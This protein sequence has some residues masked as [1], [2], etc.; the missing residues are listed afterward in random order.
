MIT[1]YYRCFFD[2]MLSTH[3]IEWRFA[4]F[5][6]RTMRHVKRKSLVLGWKYIISHKIIS[7]YIWLYR[8]CTTN[9]YTVCKFLRCGY[10]CEELCNGRSTC[11]DRT[12]AHR[13]F[14][15]MGVYLQLI[16][17]ISRFRTNIAFI[18]Q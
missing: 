1:R 17:H 6:L 10:I 8:N 2:I 5:F 15:F 4:I 13:T 3:F 18:T 11:D 7:G 16:H 14:V 12:F 9:I